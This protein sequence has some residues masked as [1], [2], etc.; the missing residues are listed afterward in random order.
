V[1]E[2]PDRNRDRDGTPGGDRARTG[3]QHGDGDRARNGD[4]YASGDQDR[5]GDRAGVDALVTDQY[6]DS[7][8]AAAERRA[9]DG[10]ADADIDPAVREAARVLRRALV[11]V[12]PSFRFEERLAIR[13]A[14]LAASRAR[15]LAATGGG[16]ATVLPFPD[17]V[18]PA[19]LADPLLDAILR[20]DLDP[21]DSAALDRAARE[22]GPRRPLLVGG[23][24]TSAAISLVGV[25]W[26]AWRAT[27]PTPGTMT[28]AARI[29]HQRRGST[30]GAMSGGGLGGPA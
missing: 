27:R 15:P 21:A 19:S 8:L 10:L 5:N 12:H 14:A 3:D 9:A 2:P 23:A 1:S 22:S 24:I 18:Q 16:G 11:R 20:G 17:R 28:R 26:V 4:Q 25:A 6:L 7:L 30:A 13:L 29:A